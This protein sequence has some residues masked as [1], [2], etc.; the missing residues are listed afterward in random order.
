MYTINFIYK[1]D[2]IEY[3]CKKMMTNINPK[4]VIYYDYLE[5]IYNCFWFRYTVSGGSI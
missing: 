2:K 3:I 5:I 4:N 1:Y